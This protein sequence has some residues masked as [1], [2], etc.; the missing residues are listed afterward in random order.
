VLAQVVHALEAHREVGFLEVH[1]VYKV[2]AHQQPELIAAL[3]VC[4][5]QGL[6]LKYDPRYHKT[7]LQLLYHHA[8]RQQYA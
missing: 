1:V 4:V 2:Q 7:A 8:I 3:L 6:L 5:V